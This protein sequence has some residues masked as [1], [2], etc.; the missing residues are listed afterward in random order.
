MAIARV[1]KRFGVFLESSYLKYWDR[2]VYS[3]QAGVNYLI[4]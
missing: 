2:R 3:A 4:F 1:G